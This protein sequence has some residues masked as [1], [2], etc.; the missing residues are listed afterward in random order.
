MTGPDAP[1]R[2]WV[3]QPRPHDCPACQGF[4]YE[5]LVAG[6][7]S[8]CRACHGSGRDDVTGS[9]DPGTVVR[10]SGAPETHRVAGET[11]HATHR[12]RVKAPGHEPVRPARRADDAPMRRGSDIP[13][14]VPV[15]RSPDSAA[16]ERD[17]KRRDYARVQ[18]A[19]REEAQAEEPPPEPIVVEV[20]GLH[21]LCTDV[22]RS[23]NAI[24]ARVERAS[25]DL[26]GPGSMGQPAL[27]HQDV[28]AVRGRA[29]PG[30][31]RATG[32][33]HALPGLAGP[34]R[35]R[36]ECPG[37]RPAVSAECTSCGAP[38]VWAL[39]ERTAKPMPFDPEPAHGGTWSIRDRGGVLVA[40]HMPDAAGGL[41][42]VSHFATCPN[43]DHHRRPR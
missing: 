18:Q 33:L 10:D 21:E 20:P 22:A 13:E 38:I 40:V 43:A 30:H 1:T 24:A 15:P 3:D 8:V 2:G 32:R 16:R 31:P 34:A 26:A 4:Q 17:R 36:G 35:C 19:K 6:R 28:L 23:G 27:G 14:E 9:R 25:S 42:W 7:F 11:S 39:H 5:Q 37:G 29:G 41:G 12:H